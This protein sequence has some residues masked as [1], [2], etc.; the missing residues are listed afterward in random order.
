[1]CLCVCVWTV[2]AKQAAEPEGDERPNYWCESG[3]FV[4]LIWTHE[5]K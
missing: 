1:M 3:P 4:P 5:M 2:L